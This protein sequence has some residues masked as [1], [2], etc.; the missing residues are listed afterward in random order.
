[1]APR[2]I[3]HRLL[4]MLVNQ[5]S[6]YIGLSSMTSFL[7]SLKCPWYMCSLWPCVSLV[8]CL[9]GR[10]GNCQDPAQIALT[11][12]LEGNSMLSPTPLLFIIPLPT[13]ETAITVYDLFPGWMPDPALSRLSVFVICLDIWAGAKVS[14]P[15]PSKLGGGYHYSKPWSLRDKLRRIM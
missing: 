5:S 6:W 2:L 12:P 1:M 15:W 10:E 11:W 14:S 13:T 7:Q 3:F 4:L 8:W 9:T